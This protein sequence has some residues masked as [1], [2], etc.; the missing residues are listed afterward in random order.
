MRVLAARLLAFDKRQRDPFGPMYAQ[1]FESGGGIALD[2]SNAIHLHQRPRPGRD[3]EALGV[4]LR[5]SP[6]ELVRVAVVQVL[7]GLRGRA[8]RR[9]LIETLERESESLHVRTTVADEFSYQ[10]LRRET[11]DALLR[12]LNHPNP[13]IRFWA[14]FGLGSST[15]EQ[16][17]YRQLVTSALRPLIGDSGEARHFW[18]VGDEARAM[19][20]Q[21]DREMHADVQRESAAIL[22]GP[23]QD[24]A[25][26]RW[27]RC[28]CRDST[29]VHCEVV[30]SVTYRG[31]SWS[32][33][34]V[35]PRYPE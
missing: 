12:C 6:D 31:I 4:L 17:S 11:A 16:Q 9:L 33:P 2:L 29:G 23:D 15:S 10:R 27:A 32:L 21:W 7:G 13:E 18:S 25:K 14:V 3:I 8:S 1:L 5:T 35:P 19:L 28:Y 20:A 24:S 34:P 30:R 26:W 22:A